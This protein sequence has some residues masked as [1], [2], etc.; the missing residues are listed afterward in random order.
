MIIAGE[1]KFFVFLGSVQ[2]NSAVFELS[3]IHPES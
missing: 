1:K 3:K 2:G